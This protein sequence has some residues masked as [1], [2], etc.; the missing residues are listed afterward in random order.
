MDGTYREPE[1]PYSDLKAHILK[2]KLTTCGE[3]IDSVD[4]DLIDLHEMIQFGVGS[5]DEYDYFTKRG[6]KFKRLNDIN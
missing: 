4:G 6:Y 2:H 1:K 3:G 5:T